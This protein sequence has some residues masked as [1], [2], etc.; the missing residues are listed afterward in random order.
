MVVT[1]ST[2][3]CPCGRKCDELKLA[4][5]LIAAT[6]RLVMGVVDM[7][8]WMSIIAIVLLKVVTAYKICVSCERVIQ[9]K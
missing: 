2:V 1:C 5:T 3:S 8:A 4:C 9:I 7:I 6:A